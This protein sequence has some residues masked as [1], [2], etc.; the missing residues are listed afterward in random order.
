MVHSS[1]LQ[2]GFIILPRPF[3]RVVPVS[4]LGDSWFEFA[5]GRSHVHIL[6]AELQSLQSFVDNFAAIL[7]AFHDTVEILHS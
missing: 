6:R 1:H 2:T 5:S 3:D 7:Q 4:E